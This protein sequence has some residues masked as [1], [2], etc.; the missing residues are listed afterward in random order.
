MTGI[1]EIY[2]QEGLTTN[3]ISL[4]DAGSEARFWVFPASFIFSRYLEGS[5]RRW[6]TRFAAQYGYVRMHFSGMSIEI[7]NKE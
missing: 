1:I 3:L 5:K 7:K 4:D 6:W 2:F